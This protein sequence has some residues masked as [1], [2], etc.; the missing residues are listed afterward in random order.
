MYINRLVRNEKKCI[1]SAI[2]CYKIAVV[3]RAMQ[4]FIFS[5]AHK[6][7]NTNALTAQYN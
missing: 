7:T 4:Y 3:D 2:K 6:G 5:Q 1:K